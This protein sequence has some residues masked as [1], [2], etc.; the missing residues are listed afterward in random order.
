MRSLRSRPATSMRSPRRSARAVSWRFDVAVVDA[1][2]AS[3]IDP[4]IAWLA[5]QGSRRAAIVEEIAAA[6]GCYRRP[7]ADY[8]AL[9]WRQALQGRQRAFTIPG[10]SR[11][12]LGVH[13]LHRGTGGG[14]LQRGSDPRFVR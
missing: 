4:Q 2:L 13:G 7:R 10:L 14:C 3:A 12:C 11:R 1:V 9:S 5:I 8:P 6:V